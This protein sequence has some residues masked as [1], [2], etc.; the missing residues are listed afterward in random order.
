MSLSYVTTSKVY[1]WKSS[2]SHTGLVMLCIRFSA[3]PA[4]PG[5]SHVFSETCK[6]KLVATCHLVHKKQQDLMTGWWWAATCRVVSSGWDRHPETFCPFLRAVPRGKNIYPYTRY[7]NTEEQRKPLHVALPHQTP[8]SYKPNSSAERDF[9]SPKTSL[10]DG[11]VKVHVCT[12][13]VH[14]PLC[15]IDRHNTT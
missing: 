11:N 15:W 7:Q 3:E 8:W 13:L 2:S 10:E 1:R 6:K 14:W 12:S 5:S 9:N 4:L